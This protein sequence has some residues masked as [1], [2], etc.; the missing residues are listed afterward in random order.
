MTDHPFSSIL[1]PIYNHERYIGA[2]LDSVVAQTDPSWEAI[3]VDDGSTD[4]SASIIDAYAARDPRITVV[5]KPNGGVASALNEGLR[6]ARGE[7]V[8]WLSSDDMFKPE[9]LAINRRWIA[10]NPG[11]NFFFSYFWLLREASGA[12]ERHPLWGPLPE[13]EHQILALFHR[14]Y[15]SGISICVNREAWRKAGS[16][17]ENFYYAQDYDQWLR[18]LSKNKGVFIPEWTVVNRNHPGQGSEIFQAACYFDTAK[19]AITFVNNHSFPELVP[20]VDLAD[21]AAATAAVEKALEVAC[22]QTAYVYSLGVHPALVLRILEW[23]FSD[24]AARSPVKSE[25]RARVRRRVREMALADGDD[26]WHWMW[27]GVAAA[28]ACESA[29]F[30]Y[31]PIDPRALARREHAARL[32]GRGGPEEPLRVYLRRFDAIEVSPQ[33]PVAA[34]SDRIAILATAEQ[35]GLD[36]AAALSAL[37]HRTIVIANDADHYRA[38]AAVPVVPRR[39]PDRDCLPWLGRVELAI[40]LEDVEASPWIDARAILSLKGADA[41]DPRIVVERALEALGYGED[42]ANRR[43]VVFFERVLS[44]GGAE[45][46]VHDLARHL[47]RRRFRPLI[48]TIFDARNQQADAPEIPYYCVRDFLLRAAAKAPATPDHGRFRDETAG[49][50]RHLDVAAKSIAPAG[51]VTARWA[52]DAARMPRRLAS[53][54]TTWIRRPFAKPSPEQSTEQV[55]QGSPEGCTAALMDSIG[56]HRPAA[57]GLRHALSELAPAAALIT[58]MEEAATIAWWAQIGGEIPFIAWL[59]TFESI[60]LPQIYSDPRR[61]EVERWAFASACSIARKTVF[62][63]RGTANDIVEHFS[64]ARDKV[65]VVHN[66][67]NCPFIRRQSWMHDPEAA[68][69]AKDR[70]AVYVHVGR[71]APEKDHQLLVEASARLKALRRDF[72]V[73]CVGDG[74]ERERLTKEIS[75]LGLRDNVLLLGHRKNPFSVLA[76]AHALILTSRIESFALVLPE[77]MACGVPV[78]SIDCQAGPRE[79]L[80]DGKS[81]I[82]IERR[83]PDA[84]ARAMIRIVEDRE[85]RLRLIGAGLARVEAFDVRRVARR[86]GEMIERSLPSAAAPC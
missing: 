67:I 31:E 84:L 79:V 76:H 61:H 62:P 14:N 18:L 2:A 38:A 27:R 57:R 5:H 81:G 15:I 65:A 28:C 55:L 48:F 45:R 37:G 1:I 58:V 16:F 83:E 33:R 10:R 21:P 26:Y 25:L 82:L 35:T 50:E 51:T 36:A 49:R 69:L 44:G 12:V 52:A 60:Y 11:V 80:E 17:D 86:W 73:L 34:G 71:L 19:A 75:R 23:V 3:V 6:R 42:S 59:H 8:H 13:P 74:P 64:V 30:A 43:P 22:D 47:D 53:V 66:P 54:A 7:W 63:S 72:I 20:W 56:V 24:E 9:K 41:R 78:I 39:S 70:G 32:T 77:A 40:S 85:L 46:A 29:K 4:G 68:A